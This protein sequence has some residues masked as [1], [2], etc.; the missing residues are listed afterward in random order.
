MSLG[1]TGDPV[2]AC[3]TT[4]DPMHRAICSSTA[5][6][7]TY[8]VA[9]GN[10]AWDFDYPSAPDVPAAYPQ[11]LTVT[12]MADSDGRPGALA[13]AP[14]CDGREADDRAAGFSNFAASATGA[15]HTIAAPGVCIRST[16]P[17][18]GYQTISGT[19]MATPHMAGAVAQCLG[20]GGQAGPCAGLAPAQ[21][22]DRVRADAQAD[23][24]ADTAFGFTGDPLRPFRGAYFGYLPRVVLGATAPPPPS[25]EPSTEPLKLSA[26]G[27]K[28]K[29]RQ[30][31]RLSWT[32]AGRSAQI[33]VLRNGALVATTTNDGAYTDAIGAKGSATYTYKVCETGTSTCSGQ[34]TVIF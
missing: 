5:A 26:S 10:S 33:T 31:V 23:N 24:D 28:I 14:G 1:A 9:A 8:V 29:G 15:A 13:G 22:I 21:V 2:G 16:W 11:V 25:E 32:P 34:V 17:G 30:R 3:S 27:E 20:E 12:A 7:I 6:G 4:S 19:S 18:G